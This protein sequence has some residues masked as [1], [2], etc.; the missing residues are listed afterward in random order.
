MVDLQQACTFVQTKPEHQ[1]CFDSMEVVE[2]EELL[3]TRGIGGFLLRVDNSGALHVSYTTTSGPH[4]D[5]L[6]CTSSKG[7]SEVIFSLFG[8][9]STSVAQL[10]WSFRDRF[11]SPILPVRPDY[12]SSQDFFTYARVTIREANEEPARLVTYPVLMTK[13]QSVSD[14]VAVVARKAQVPPECCQSVGYWH[15]KDG[16]TSKEMVRSDISLSSAEAQR[17]ESGFL[18]L[19]FDHVPWRSGAEAAPEIPEVTHVPE[20]PMASTAPEVPE[21]LRSSCSTPAF[22]KRVMTY[23]TPASGVYPTKSGLRLNHVSDVPL[24]PTHARSTISRTGGG[25][26]PAAACPRVI[27]QRTSVGYR[28]SVLSARSPS[29]ISY[30]GGRTTPNMIATP[31]AGGYNRGPPLRSKSGDRNA[32][33]AVLPRSISPLAGRVRVVPAQPS[34]STTSTRAV[35]VVSP[36]RAQSPLRLVTQGPPVF[37]RPPGVVMSLPGPASRGPVYGPRVPR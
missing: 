6:R 35:S 16:G 11:L 3:K 15:P 4:H 13:R 28:P 33:V 22:A 31:G 25:G 26:T 29:P 1:C 18:D 34:A 12:E 37:S 21:R 30:R 36:L 2:A 24:D 17:F 7:D 10:L 23:V 19:H 20:V 5:S 27:P 9:S 8:V 14:L 32:A